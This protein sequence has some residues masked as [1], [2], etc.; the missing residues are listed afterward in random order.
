MKTIEELNVKIFCDGARLE[1]FKKMKS[2]PFIKGYT[3]NPTLMKKAGIVDYEK[4]IK[5]ITPVVTDKPLSFE[6]IADDFDEMKRQAIKLNSYAPNI[7]VKIPITNTKSQSSIPLIEQLTKEGI[8]L[9]ITAIMTLKQVDQLVKVLKDGAPAFVSVFAGRIA[10]TG[11]DPVPIM[12]QAKQFCKE[13]KGVELL[14]ASSREL[15]NIFQAEDIGCDIITVTPDIIK[16]LKYVGYDLAE[17]SLD[18]VKMFYKDALSS[19]LTL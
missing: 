17:F 9:N 2:V 14:W 19:R 18:T 5:T 1:D 4:F 7:Y 3:T 15:L 6:V 10:N 13:H 16:N 8:K 11:R 12:K